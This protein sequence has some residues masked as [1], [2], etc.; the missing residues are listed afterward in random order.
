V[1]GFFLKANRVFV[2]GGGVTSGLT[3]R[4]NRVISQILATVDL[5][6]DAAVTADIA[7]SWF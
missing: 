7:A 5:L 6:Y 1:V 4:F 3:R 2:V